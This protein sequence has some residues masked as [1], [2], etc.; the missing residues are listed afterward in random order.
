MFTIKNVSKI[1]NSRRGTVKALDN[2]SFNIARGSFVTI[3][4]GSGSGK[5]TI[6]LTLGG[7]IRPTEGKV[8]FVDKN[9]FDSSHVNLAEYRNQ[10][11]ALSYRHLI[12]CRTFLR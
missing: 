8:V 10:K 2:I 6:L 4:G 12:S 11:S 7:L 5:S 9:L 3:T 1:Y